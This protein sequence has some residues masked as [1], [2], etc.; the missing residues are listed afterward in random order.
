MLPTW[1]GI[2]GRQVILDLLTYLPMTL[3]GIQND[4]DIMEMEVSHPENRHRRLAECELR[5]ANSIA[6]F[7]T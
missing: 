5:P 3:D 6:N 4:E 1:N 7:L 2:T